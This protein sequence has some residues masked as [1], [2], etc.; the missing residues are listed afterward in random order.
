[1]NKE[2]IFIARPCRNC[3]VTDCGWH[4]TPDNFKLCE[5]YK[6]NLEGTNAIERE[7]FDSMVEYHLRL[8]IGIWAKYNPNVKE[9]NTWIYANGKRYNVRIEEDRQNLKYADKDTMMPGA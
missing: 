1:M 7:K 2:E 4:D 6:V 3:Q 8:S 5:D 9:L